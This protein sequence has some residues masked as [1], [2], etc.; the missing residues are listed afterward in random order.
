MS[1]KKSSHRLAA[2]IIEA[3]YLE[4]RLKD[5]KTQIP[6]FVLLCN[7]GFFIESLAVKL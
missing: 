7:V 6:V 4:Y 5:S 3:L 2:L 1:L